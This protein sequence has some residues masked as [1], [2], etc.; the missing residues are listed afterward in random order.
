MSELKAKARAKLPEKAFAG[1][2]KSYP[3]PDKA[4]ASNAEARA[5]QAVKAGRMSKSG[6]KSIDAKADQ[7]LRAR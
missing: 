6:E 2:G 1:P 5:S 7:K 3:I 4:H